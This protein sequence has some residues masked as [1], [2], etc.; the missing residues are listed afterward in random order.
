MPAKR[1]PGKPGRSRSS[2]K[3]GVRWSEWS[4][5]AT[6]LEL[7]GGM[8]AP[9]LGDIGPLMIRSEASFGANL[10]R[11]EACM[12]RSPPGVAQAAAA[13]PGR[14]PIAE[15]Q[16]RRRDGSPGAA[17]GGPASEN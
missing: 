17:A 6:T 13:D 15:G 5:P 3:S 10:R 7:C 9:A 12:G 8:H 11:I 1:R 16:A 2:A 4:R 14:G